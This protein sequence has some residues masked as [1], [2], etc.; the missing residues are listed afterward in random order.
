MSRLDSK[1]S[2]RDNSELCWRLIL[3]DAWLDGA[4]EDFSLSV[5]A[6][7]LEGFFGWLFGEM[8][9]VLTLW[10]YMHRTRIY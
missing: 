9:F 6:H 7:T 2:T 8:N 4:E 1:W 10:I 5:D 3:N